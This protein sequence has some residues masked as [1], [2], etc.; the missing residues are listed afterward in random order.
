MS[1][2]FPSDASAMPPMLI[3]LIVVR[4]RD[5]P[6]PERMWNGRKKHTT[7]IKRYM[8]GKTSQLLT[9]TGFARVT[10]QKRSNMMPRGMDRK[11]ARR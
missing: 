6:E 11:V 1:P 8:F 2:N 10:S 7:S 5:R 9:A 4:K 3:L